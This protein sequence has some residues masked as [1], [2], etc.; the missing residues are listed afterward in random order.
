MS[1]PTVDKVNKEIARKIILKAKKRGIPLNTLACYNGNYYYPQKRVKKTQ[2]P[3]QINDNNKLWL[4]YIPE[5]DMWCFGYEFK[6]FDQKGRCFSER[7]DAMPMKNKLYSSWSDAV[8]AGLH[9]YADFMGDCVHKIDENP[10]F[11]AYLDNFG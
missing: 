11:F 8:T 10:E 5:N 7:L 6:F 9:V 2:Q 4:Y 3:Y 1:T